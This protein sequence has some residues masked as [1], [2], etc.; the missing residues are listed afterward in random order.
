MGEARRAA[1]AAL[2]DTEGS[3]TAVTTSGKCV[4][5]KHAAASATA[6]ASLMTFCSSLHVARPGAMTERVERRRLELGRRARAGRREEVVNERAQ[7]LDASAQRRQVDGLGAEARREIRAQVVEEHR[8]AVGRLDET[9]PGFVGRRVG[10][11]R[12]RRARSRRAR[13]EWQR[14]DDEPP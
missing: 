14:R 8:A 1:G 4:R 6:I 3:M 10:A 2:G 12:D 7:I 11:A 5:R 9:G 13:P